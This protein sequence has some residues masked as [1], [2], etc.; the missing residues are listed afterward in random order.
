MF[1]ELEDEFGYEYC[2]RHQI[3]E[4]K[5]EDDEDI[6]NAKMWKVEMDIPYGNY[7]AKI[8]AKM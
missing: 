6:P 3:I 4:M 5:E 8:K 2:P 1:A 7:T